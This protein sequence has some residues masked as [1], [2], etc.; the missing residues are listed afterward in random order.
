VTAALLICRIMFVI[1]ANHE[2][3]VQ[4]QLDTYRHDST[5][6]NRPYPHMDL[7]P[8]LDFTAMARGVGVPAAHRRSRRVAGRSAPRSL[9]SRSP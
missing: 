9:P 5:Q 2:Y 4:A 6:S 3:R 7:S 8:P 1:L